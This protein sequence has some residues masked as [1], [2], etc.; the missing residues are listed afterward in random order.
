MAVLEPEPIPDRRVLGE[1]GEGG[2]PGWLSYTRATPISQALSPLLLLK[3]YA[4]MRG[5]VYRVEPGQGAPVCWVFKSENGHYD[6]NHCQDI[7]KCVRYFT[8]RRS[9]RLVGGF[10]D[11]WGLILSMIVQA[12]RCTRAIDRGAI[13]TRPVICNKIPRAQRECNCQIVWLKLLRTSG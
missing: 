2:A 9:Q 1:R 11:F 10:P 7:K 5:G 6:K 3:Y 4:C 12:A 13:L 8:L